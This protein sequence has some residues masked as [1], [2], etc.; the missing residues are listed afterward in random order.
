MKCDVYVQDVSNWDWFYA[1]DL[2]QFS[3]C[4]PFL[5]CTSEMQTSGFK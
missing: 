3:A 5:V 1:C 4:L 2:Q